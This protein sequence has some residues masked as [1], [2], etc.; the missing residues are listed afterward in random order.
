[1]DHIEDPTPQS[2]SGAESPS[3]ERRL[4]L[5]EEQ[6]AE[7]QNQLRDYE[8]SLV[9]RIADVDD[10]RRTTASK[11]QRAWQTQREEIDD[12][13]RRQTRTTLVVLLMFALFFAV[14]LFLAYRQLESG[15]KPLVE[16]MDRIEQEIGRLS[17]NRGQD[18]PLKAELTRLSASVGEISTALERVDQK[19][20][21][22]LQAALD[23]EQAARAKEDGRLSSDL[24]RLEAD[25][26]RLVDE[27]ESLRGTLKA[28]EAGQPESAAVAVTSEP[29]PE[30]ASAG[31]TAAAAVEESPAEQSAAVAEETPGTGTEETS[32][33]SEEAG[34]AGAQTV[35]IDNRT[36]ALQLIGFFR[37]DAMEQFVG[38]HE[39]PDQVYYRLDTYRGRPWFALIY[40]LHESYEAAEAEL[41]RLPPEL[42]ALDP[43]IRPLRPG[44]QLK[45][46]E[47][48]TGR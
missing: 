32:P 43:W 5:L 44:D 45:V 42:V 26:K 30:T 25:Q 19:P 6:L 41:S 35:S 3:L 12:V 34:G 31:K 24:Q 36:Y 13:L 11:L 16:E 27:L 37:Q 21:G 48:G 4:S 8:K 2:P 29:A 9:E 39:L 7:Q 15:R 40:S 47:A 18:D 10:D 28:L 23:D 1:M 14:V 17:G 33:E 46:L 20:A 22:N 38:R